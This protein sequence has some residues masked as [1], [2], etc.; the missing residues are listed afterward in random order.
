METHGSVVVYVYVVNLCEYI[1]P[2]P[3]LF[4]KKAPRRRCVVFRKWCF[5]LECD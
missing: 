1:F 2:N 5:S 3:K 4:L